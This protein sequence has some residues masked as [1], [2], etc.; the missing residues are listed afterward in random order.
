MATLGTLQGP[1]SGAG[2]AKGWCLPWRSQAPWCSWRWQRCAWHVSNSLGLLRD[3]SPKHWKL[4]RWFLL[5]VGGRKWNF[6]FQ[7]LLFITMIIYY[8]YPAGA[9]VEGSCSLLG[10]TQSCVLWVK[11]LGSL[12]TTW[13]CL[14]TFQFLSEKGAGSWWGP[15]P[16]QL[17]KQGTAAD[18]QA[19]ENSWES[20]LFNLILPGCREIWGTSCS[21]K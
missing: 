12:R 17:T 19:T 8:C 1:E 15:F 2:T 6:L 3:F 20:P 7:M 16:A 9:G 4:L 5:W 10:V 21:K 13:F 14:F 11:Q 18:A